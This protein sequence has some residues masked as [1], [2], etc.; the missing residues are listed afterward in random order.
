MFFKMFLLK[1]LFT[2]YEFNKKIGFSKLY[3][4]RKN[5]PSKYYEILNKELPQSIFCILG[6]NFF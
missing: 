2:D 1:K 5:C 3:I 6:I 4:E